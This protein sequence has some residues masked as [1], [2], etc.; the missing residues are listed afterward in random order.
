MGQVS[1][2]GSVDPLVCAGSN[3]ASLAHRKEWET[4]EKET[5]G[6][7]GGHLPSWSPLHHMKPLSL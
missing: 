7:C 5:V 4:S 6:V 2:E 3:A 1:L